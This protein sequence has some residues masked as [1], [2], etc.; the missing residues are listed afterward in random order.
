VRAMT[1]P[2]QHPPDIPQIR[3]RDH[4]LVGALGQPR[5]GG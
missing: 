1:R 5:E 4:A 3:E 2:C